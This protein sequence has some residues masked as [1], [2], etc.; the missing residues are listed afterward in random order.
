MSDIPEILK[1][2]KRWILWRHL[3]GRKPPVDADGTPD[4]AWND[5][6]TWMVFQDAL[7]KMQASADNVDGVG[8]VLGGGWGG[9][10]LDHCRSVENG[11][12]DPRAEAVIQIAD[13]YTEVS[14]SGQGLKIFGRSDDGWLELT[15]FDG[16]VR[17]DAKAQGYFAVTGKTYH[18]GGVTETLDFKTI[19]GYFGAEAQ[20]SKEK[21]KR[22]LG[23]D[24]RPGTQNT[25]L[26]REACAQARFGKSEHEIFALLRAIADERCAPEEGREPWDDAAIRA[27]ARSA[28]RFAPTDDPFPCDDGGDA[29]FFAKQCEDLVRFN[30]R[31]SLWL[32]WD[33]TRWCPD[34]KRSIYNHA[35]ESM[36]SRHL[37]ATNIVDESVKKARTAW[38]KSGAN[39]VRL[40]HMLKLASGLSPIAAAGDE[41]DRDVMLL[42]VEN[43]VINLEKGYHRNSKP[44]DMIT[45]QAR[46]RYDVDAKCPQW[47]RT[48]R[49]IFKD[50]P[51]LI[52]YVQRAFGYSLT[53]R[54]DE[55]V[56]FLLIGGGRNGKGTLVNTFSRILGDY[57]D[58]LNFSALEQHNISSGGGASPDLA[59]LASKRF[60][61]ASEANEGRRLDEAK[62]K[63]IT[64]RDDVT[65]RFLYGRFFT[66]TPEFKLWLSCN[67]LPRVKD[68]SEGFWSRP[69]QVPFEQNYTGREDKKLKERLWEE[70]A[71]ILNWAIDGALAW[72][73]AGLAPP[74]VIERVKK[75]YRKSQETLAQFY[76]DECVLA[77]KAQ[78]GTV[79][80]FSA[81]CRWFEDNRFRFSR[82][83]RKG[84]LAEVAKRTGPKKRN[85]KGYYFSGVGLASHGAEEIL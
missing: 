14:P 46:V 16:H 9:I 30:H 42:G 38:T 54:C 55:E 34:E 33:G 35:T 44:E 39:L 12:I 31:S 73:E 7:E 23:A 48:I 80:L 66:Y 81:Y 11:A 49:D 27:I 20:V 28:S 79:D 69:H 4:K 77:D 47:E 78:A 74:E 82:L 41:F 83:G 76:E 40:D 43:G 72:Q 71:G 85:R 64:G 32:I 51:E 61:T 5:A 36:R 57:S 15:F 13:S 67:H 50:N 22:V 1:N 65:A 62:I 3:D 19:A 17:V 10:D 58:N 18:P 75:M 24:I 56:F 59:K 21:P 26:F 29:A 52:P 25:E 84:F 60:V 6:S 45:M 53:G 8:F 2:E 70:R 63:A 37:I 68:D